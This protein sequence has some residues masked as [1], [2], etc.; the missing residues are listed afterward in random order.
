ML[1]P[2]SYMMHPDMS[3]TFLMHIR[4]YPT[5]VPSFVGTLALSS[6]ISTC[7]FVYLVFCIYTVIEYNYVLYISVSN[8]SFSASSSHAA[9]MHSM[10][11]NGMHNKTSMVSTRHSMSCDIILQHPQYPLRTPHDI[12]SLFIVLLHYSIYNRISFCENFLSINDGL[13]ELVESLFLE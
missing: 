9:N 6:C 1:M 11:M 2:V 8:S 12:F 5:C 7:M 13:C 4:S 3:L 10:G